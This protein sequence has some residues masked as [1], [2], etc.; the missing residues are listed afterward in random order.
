MYMAMKQVRQAHS[1]SSS[2]LAW[3][4]STS[5][6]GLAISFLC[7]SRC[8]VMSICTSAFVV[9]WGRVLYLLPVSDPWPKVQLGREQV[10]RVA[11]FHIVCRLAGIF[12]AGGG[13]RFQVAGC[14]RPGGNRR[15]SRWLDG[16]FH[17]S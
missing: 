7:A 15:P 4:A 9:Q 2:S 12:E 11:G 14:F 8:R 13:V 3:Q 1:S 6:L 17:R 16:F 5:G 10:R